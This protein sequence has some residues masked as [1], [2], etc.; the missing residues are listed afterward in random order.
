MLLS[1][2]NGFSV[3]AVMGLGPK[4]ENKKDKKSGKD[5]NRS[6]SGN[7]P[8]YNDRNRRRH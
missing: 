8:I 7:K 3:L 4:P 2:I 1:S 6:N 5:K